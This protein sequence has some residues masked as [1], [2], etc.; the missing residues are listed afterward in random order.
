MEDALRK[1]ARP[2]AALAIAQEIV[3]LAQQ[4]AQQSAHG[5]S[6]SPLQGNGAAAS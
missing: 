1:L 4:N 5:P 6:Q 3:A 2:Q